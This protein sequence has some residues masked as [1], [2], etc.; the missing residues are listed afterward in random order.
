MTIINHV[1]TGALVAVAVDKPVIALPAALLSHFVLDVVPHWDYKFKNPLHKQAA[2]MIDMTLTLWLLV[3][4]AALFHP[5]ARLL[6]AGGF[7][8]ILPDAMWLPEVIKG[9]PAKLDGQGLFYKLRYF[10]HKIQNEPPYGRYV[11]I[12]WFIVTLTLLVQVLR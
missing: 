6:I 3:V 1:T 9:V 11:E 2:I 8:G 10:H 4:L 12:C 7:L 5:S